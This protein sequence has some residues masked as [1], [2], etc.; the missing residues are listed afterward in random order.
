MCQELQIFCSCIYVLGC[1][2][3]LVRTC[4]SKFE[5]TPLGDIIIVIIIIVNV[6]MS[7]IILPTKQEREFLGEKKIW[8]D[9]TIT[10]VKQGSSNFPKIYVETILKLPEG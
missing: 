4:D 10:A 8:R 9:E 6:T 1:K 2:L 3:S 7:V 5:I